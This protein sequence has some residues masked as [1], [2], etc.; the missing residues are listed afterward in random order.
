MV[1]L[2]TYGGTQFDKNRQCLPR[3]TDHKPGGLWLTEDV[4]DGWKNYVIKSIGQR[5]QEWCYGDVKYVTVFEGDPLCCT[6]SVLTIAD[7]ED[8]CDLI[9]SYLEN[10]ERNCKSEDLQQ[11]IGECPSSCS[12]QCYNCYG[13]HIKWDRVRDDYKGLA[14][15]FYTE[16]I[17]HL[18][19]ESKL[20]WSRFNCAS[21]CFWDTSCLTLV[22]ENVAT[23]YTCNGMCPSA[24]CPIR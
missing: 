8:L 3:N 20:H 12:G 10:S 14:L 17:S 24:Y 18:S 5:P 7:E 6:D 2:Y 9:S 13:F 16:D 11:I 19:K 23:G 4:T 15:T 22:E 21:W 1:T